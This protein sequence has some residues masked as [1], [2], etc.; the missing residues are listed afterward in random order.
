MDTTQREIF[1]DHIANR[2][3]FPLGGPECHDIPFCGTNCRYCTDQRLFESARIPRI[4]DE[5]FEL[6]CTV[7]RRDDPYIG[8]VVPDP[9][10]HPRF[11]IYLRE[12]ALRF[13][14]TRT[15]VATPG[16]P[17]DMELIEF[18][19]AHPSIEVDIALNTFD[20]DL[21]EIILGKGHALKKVIEIIRR[22]DRVQI[23]ITYMGDVPLLLNDIAR[24]RVLT[25][26]QQEFVVRRLEHSKYNPEDVQTLS[27]NS[28]PTY[29]QALQTLRDKIDGWQYVCPDVELILKF[30]ME[31]LPQDGT[32]YLPYYV[33]RVRRRL[34]ASGGTRYLFCS[35]PSSARYWNRMLARY[36][37]V[38]VVSVENTTFAG[39]FCAAGFMTV[40]D[41]DRIATMFKGC[42]DMLILP[43][44]ML[45]HHGEDITGRRPAELKI[46]YVMV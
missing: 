40:E 35:A 14:E 9:F 18:I 26:R 45:D 43:I 22:L 16:A 20:V 12:F 44:G 41:V 39:S 13:P 11:P 46:P 17:F 36:P 28:I 1:L 23:M 29:G 33:Q 7:V 2:K 24:L 6:G 3:F 38:T 27:R 30:G 32:E 10:T 25:G 8:F 19:N 4:T 5:E 15:V 34:E 21:R 42:Y 37:R 31:R